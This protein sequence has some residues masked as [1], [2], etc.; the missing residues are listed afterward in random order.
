ML[1]LLW[2]D[3]QSVRV[4]GRRRRRAAHGLSGGVRQ[5]GRRYSHVLLRA[6]P[7]SGPRR[8]AEP[9]ASEELLHTGTVESVM[10]SAQRQMP[11][12]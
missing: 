9:R 8:P 3:S 7:S 10:P 4:P 12:T 1:K 11:F 6:L 2:W 5:E